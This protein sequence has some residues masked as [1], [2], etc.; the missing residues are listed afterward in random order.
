VG[1][2]VQAK[3]KESVRMSI[4]AEKTEAKGGAR[5][6]VRVIIHAL[7]LALIVRVFLFQPFN[8]PSG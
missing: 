5:D 3:P 2:G 8:I 7:I 1:E 6:T 4:E